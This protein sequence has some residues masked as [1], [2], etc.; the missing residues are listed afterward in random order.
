MHHDRWQANQLTTYPARGAIGVVASTQWSADGYN[1]AYRFIGMEER[2]FTQSRDHFS[3]ALHFFEWFV[4][5]YLPELI[6]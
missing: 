3:F 2:S 6:A 4:A 1:T 5:E